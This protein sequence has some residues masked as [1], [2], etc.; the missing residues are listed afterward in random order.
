MVSP[1]ITN[2]Y[3]LSKRRLQRQRFEKFSADIASPFALG[4]VAVDTDLTNDYTMPE[5]GKLG[6]ALDAELTAAGQLFVTSNDGR[7]VGVDAAAADAI[8]EL[9]FF[10]SGLLIT[11]QSAVAGAVTLYVFDTFGVPRA[12]ATGT[13][14]A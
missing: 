11:V 10:Q 13:V 5:A 1:T 12:I 2:Q 14:T 3:L 7:T 6:I 9:S 8:Q 4:T